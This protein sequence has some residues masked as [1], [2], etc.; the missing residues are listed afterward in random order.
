MSTLGELSAAALA[1]ESSQ[2]AIEFEKRWITWGEMRHVAER[3]N[4]LI[5]ASGAPAG[6]P[7][8]LIARNRPSA[9][10]TLL[11]LIAKGCTVR[12]IYPFQ[13]PAAIARNVERLKPAVVVAAAGEFSD[14]MRATLRTHG[15]AAIAI[16]DMDATAVPGLERS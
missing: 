6:A 10:A 16:S 1:R 3:L 15:I 2:T 4:A 5:D 7:V 12:M 11:G 8:A 13:S 14:E 9:V